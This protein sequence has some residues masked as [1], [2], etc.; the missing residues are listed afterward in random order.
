MMSQIFVTKHNG[1]KEALDLNKF[2]KV[3]EWA[4]EGL[5]NV[6]ESEIELKSHIQFYNGIKT[7]DI[8]ETLIKAAADLIGEDNP[9]YQY[10]AGRLINYHL[11]KQ[12]YG[13]YNIPHLRD[14]LR[15][16]IEQGF[17]DKDIEIPDYDFFSPMALNHSK[18]LAD[19]YFRQGFSDVEAKAGVHY[20]TYKVFVNF[21]QI[22]DITQIDSK[23][24]SSLK[25][26]AVIKHAIRNARSLFGD[27]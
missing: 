4:C 24:F 20:G 27:V 21:F 8:Q 2:H 15:L 7:S 10:V 16:V 11:R 14:H 25:K 26:N 17:Y 13:D 19:I 6:S 5:S 23:L 18:E 9:G 22:A 12:V 1:N 3:V